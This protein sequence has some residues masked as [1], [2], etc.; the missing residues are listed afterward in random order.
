[1]GC[2]YDAARKDAESYVRYL[3]DRRSRW[4]VKQMA[5]QEGGFEQMVLTAMCY[6][7][8]GTSYKDGLLEYGKYLNN[9]YHHTLHKNQHDQGIVAGARHAVWHTLGEW[10]NNLDPSL[11]VDDEVSDRPEKRSIDDKNTDMPSASPEGSPSLGG[12]PLGGSTPK[13]TTSTLEPDLVQYYSV[14]SKVGTHRETRAVLGM[15][16]REGEALRMR[17]HRRKKGAPARY[18]E[19]GGI[20]Q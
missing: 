4:N 17:M 12:A 5:T 3:L 6:M 10:I 11:I 1:M 9:E 15:S 18:P 19:G 20:Y 14:Y 8:R 16:K 13:V 7:L 2:K